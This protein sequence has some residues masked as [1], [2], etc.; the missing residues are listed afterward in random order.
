MKI[1]STDL[2]LLLGYVIAIVLFGLW[3]GRRKKDITDYTVGG[4]D[5]PCWLVLFSIVATET[6]TV[7]FLSIPGFG[8]QHDL[9]WLQLPM[10][11]VLGR[12]LVVGILLPRYFRGNLFTAYEVLEQRF[13]GATKRAASALF[14]ITRNLA[15]G[16]R[17]FLTALVLQKVAGIEL[18]PAVACI[19]I[20]TIV[21]TFFGGMKA[22]VWTD[23]VQFVVYMVGAL[24]A[25]WLL[26]DGV[27]GGWEQVSA[28]ASDAGKWRVFDFGFDLTNPYVFWAGLVG[29][30][31]LTLGT[32]GTDQMM[33]QRYLC[34]RDQRSAGWALG[35]SGVVVLLQFA[36]FLVIGVV[37]WV[38]YEGAA[39]FDRNDEIF[40]AF[41]VNETPPVL[42]GL[43]LGAVFSAA[44][45][46]LSSSLNSS[47]TTAV[48]D[49][50]V[51]LA[52]PA[53]DPA[54]RLRMVRTM[55]IVFGVIQIGIGIA[56]QW[57]VDAVVNNVLAIAGFTTGIILGVFFL[58]VFTRHIGQRAALV[59]LV[60]GLVG[61]TTIKFATD[62]AWP[63]FA[64]VGSLGTFCI[65]WIASKFVAEPG[66]RDSS[67]A[68]A[69]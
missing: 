42:R 10:G 15:D 49:L 54:R 8:Y 69:K 23:F 65:G 17:L 30:A 7:T 21:Y 36:L 43:L 4:R 25:F 58:G 22:V 64:F 55:T 37:L 47:A 35:L 56:G 11:Y 3:I 32:H 62:L 59:A 13:G 45:S 34:A 9:T 6:S 50:Y 51:P 63:W 46:T 28:V 12:L 24:I 60:A 57:T 14:L 31:F 67:R 38:F 41:I 48:L 33:V 2:A 66:E 29:G 26:V 40:A 44:M 1:G 18:A 19:G 27:P 5:L 68:D 52:E 20:A 61:M 39:A 16:L 53:A